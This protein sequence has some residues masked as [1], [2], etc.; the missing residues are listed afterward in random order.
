MRWHDT[1]KQHFR[2][3]QRLQGGV[4]QLTGAT[5][6]PPPPLTSF[7]RFQHR[8]PMW[9]HAQ[10]TDAI[11]PSGAAAVEIY[12]VAHLVSRPPNRKKVHVKKKL[13]PPCGLP[14]AAWRLAPSHQPIGALDPPAVTSASAPNTRSQIFVH[15]GVGPGVRPVLG[16][17][18]P[19]RAGDQ[20]VWVRVGS[21]RGSDRQHQRGPGMPEGAP[22]TNGKNT[23]QKLARYIQCGQ[24]GTHIMRSFRLDSCDRARSREERWRLRPQR[25]NPR[26]KRYKGKMGRY[27]V[28]SR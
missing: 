5:F 14:G 15:G 2:S 10:L 1:S 12:F 19:K 7:K 8:G 26:A 4:W 24:R 27:P 17:V 20:G 9:R 13:P 6:Q 21:W 18:S 11:R 22:P 23:P 28:W 25:L 3:A 16:Q